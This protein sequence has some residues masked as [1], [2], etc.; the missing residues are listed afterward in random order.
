M[1]LIT[2]VLVI[3]YVLIFSLAFFVIKL[4]QHVRSLKSQ[5]AITDKEEP[6]MPKEGLE[7]G[8]AI[9]RK[10]YMSMG[11]ESV[12]LYDGKSKI[13]LFTMNNCNACK[14]TYS[15]VKTFIAS[16]PGLPVT[17]FLYAQ[18]ADEAEEMVNTN[19]LADFQVVWADRALIDS[20]KVNRFPFA[21][22]LSDEQVILNKSVTNYLHH[23]EQMMTQLPHAKPSAF[24]KSA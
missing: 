8:V 4:Y 22:Y 16:H 1:D 13:I 21:F 10:T 14:E 6:T 9:P 19:E 18:D 5:P 20:Y 2:T 24:N 12:N 7:L 15:A 17:L 3:Q 11:G 23:F